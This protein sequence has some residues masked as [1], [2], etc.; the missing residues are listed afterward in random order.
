[1]FDRTTLKDSAGFLWLIYVVHV[2]LQ[3]ALPSIVFGVYTFELTPRPFN[4][5]TIVTSVWVY[6]QGSIVIILFLMEF[7]MMLLSVSLMDR[8][9]EEV[10]P[11][12]KS[13]D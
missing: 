6:L 5:G 8:A 7:I 1:M 13:S 11:D 10:N 3:L 12:V 2:L 9:A 4:G